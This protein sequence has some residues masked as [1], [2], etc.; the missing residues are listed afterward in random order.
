MLEWNYLVCCLE[1]FNSGP[2]FIQWVKTFY[3]NIERCVINN[4]IMS[5]YF[6]MKQGVRHGDQLSPYPFV[7][8]IESLAMSI[9]NNPSI[10]K[11]R[12]ETKFFNMQFI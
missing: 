11:D 10:A 8:A 2:V 6:T 12:E 5:D 7:I 3:K 1:A 4:E 9:W